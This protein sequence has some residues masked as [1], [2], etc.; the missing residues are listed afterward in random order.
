MPDP[1]T[2]TSKPKVERPVDAGKLSGSRVVVLGCGPYRIGSSVEFDWCSVSCIKTLRSLG[3]EAI[4]INCNPETVSTDY[5]ESDRL[6]F[7]ELSHETVLDIADLERPAGVVVSVGG[8]TPNNLA[9]GLHKNGVKILG[10]SVEA[11]DMCENRFKFS[12]L[13]DSLRIDQPEWSEFTTVEEALHFCQRVHFP[14]LVR[15][16]HVLSGAAM[17]VVASNE[18]LERFLRTAAVVSRDYPVVITK[19]ISGAKEVE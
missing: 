15:P 13:C 6:Y 11:I 16:S 3:H 5:D 1:K 17:R 9:M 10:T 4:V 12:K 18:E 8:Q 14:T 2:L 7:E 19:Y